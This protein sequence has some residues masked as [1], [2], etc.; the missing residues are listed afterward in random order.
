MTIT[1]PAEQTNKQTN[2]QSTCWNFITGNVGKL[3]LFVFQKGWLCGFV[4]FCFFNCY[5]WLWFY[6]HLTVASTDIVFKDT[7]LFIISL[8]FSGPSASMVGH[9]LTDKFL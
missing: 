6:S 9:S 7:L 2:K 3:V 5:L 1:Y 8:S 4:L